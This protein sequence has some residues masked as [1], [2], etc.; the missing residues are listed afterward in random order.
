MDEMFGNDVFKA[1]KEIE[2]SHR[3]WRKEVS[4]TYDALLQKRADA[5][6]LVNRKHYGKERG[7]KSG[8]IRVNIS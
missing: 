7:R 4:E 2:S 1:I 8:V 5:R 3:P 6:R